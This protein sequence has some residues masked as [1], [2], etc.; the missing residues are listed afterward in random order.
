MIQKGIDFI[1]EKNNPFKWLKFSIALQ[2]AMA[3]GKMFLSVYS[4]S[5][6]LLSHS[7]YNLVIA[8]AK[9]LVFLSKNRNNSLFSNYK[10]VYKLIGYSIL[11]ASLLFIFFCTRMFKNGYSDSVYP[12]HIGI[13]I[14]IITFTEFFLAIK[15]IVLARKNGDTLTEA[16]KLINLV[17]SIISLSLTQIVIMSF[18]YEDGNPAFYNGFSGIFLGA[19]SAIIGFLMILKKD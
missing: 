9:Y 6:F 3:F 1:L 4:F 17:S 11:G 18:S 16:L 19:L 10:Q 12:M 13:I 8:I 5:I 2:L 7:F 14:A 15:G